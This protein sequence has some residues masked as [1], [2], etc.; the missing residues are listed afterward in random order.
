MYYIIFIIMITKTVLK[1][2]LFI[3]HLNIVN[4]K[5]NY[6]FNYEKSNIFSLGINILCLN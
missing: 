3:C 5:I 6:E 4:K 1:K 2:E